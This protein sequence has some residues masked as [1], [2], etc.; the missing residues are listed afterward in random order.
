LSSEKVIKEYESP[1]KMGLMPSDLPMTV[2][3]AKEMMEQYQ[4]LCAALLVPWRDRVIK[5]G[6]LVKDS[7]YQRI[8]V[9]IKNDRSEDVWVDKDFVKKSGWRKLAMAHRLSFETVNKS[10]EEKGAEFIYR[11]EVKAIHPNGRFSVG[12]GKASSSE[13][14]T[15]G[16]EE[17]D[18]ESTA[19]TRAVNRAV[20]DLIGFGQVSAEEA[21]T[22]GEMQPKRVESNA[23]VKDAPLSSHMTDE[24]VTGEKDIVDA[25]EAAKLQ[26]DGCLEIVTRDFGKFEISQVQSLG[27]QWGKY[28][29]VL[30]GFGAV[31]HRVEDPDPS[32]R[33]KWTIG[34]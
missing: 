31:Y 6:V 4:R 30:K 12:V 22:V 16:R 7:D 33:K 32:L 3:G 15:K 21:Q 8:K 29:E 19:Y 13:A 26:V 9:K 11:Y 34:V 28:H 23:V 24:E 18:V 1:S 25:L 5:D 17:H 20:S 10:R 27:D 2:E 14:H